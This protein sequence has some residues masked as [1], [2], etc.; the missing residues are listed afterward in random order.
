MTAARHTVRRPAARV[1][2]GNRVT[3]FRGQVGGRRQ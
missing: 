1:I 2:S 3:P